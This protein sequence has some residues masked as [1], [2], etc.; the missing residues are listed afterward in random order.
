MKRSVVLAGLSIELFIASVA[1][2]QVQFMGRVWAPRYPEAAANGPSNTGVLENYWASNRP[3]DSPDVFWLSN[4]R[5][6][7]SLDGPGSEALASRTWEMAPSG[8]YRMTGSAGNYSM[9]FTGPA[10][11][12]RPII[13]TNV[14]TGD[15]DGVDR[16]VM[17]TFDYA[18]FHDGAWDPKRASDYYQ[19]F[20]A[21]GASITTVGFRVVHDGVDGEGPGGQ[22]LLASVHKK[23][24][25]TP[26]T[27]EQVGPAVAVPNVDSGGGKMYNWTAAWL[28]GEVPTTPGETYAVHLRAEK[29]GGTFQMFW[30]PDE[31]RESDCYRVGEQGGTGFQGRD[32]WMAISSDCDGLLIAYNKRIQKEYVHLVGFAHKYT[33]TYVARGRS[34]AGVVTYAAFGGAQPGIPR[35]RVAVRVREGG[36]DGPQVGI[37]KIAI[38]NGIHTGDASWGTFGVVFAP[39]EVPL[40]PGKTYAIEME[41]IENYE[42]LHGYVNIKGAVSD[43]RPGFNPY[44]MQAPETYEQG[45]AYRN[46]TED[47]GLDLEMQIVEYERSA[48]NWSQAVDAAN[49]LANGD[50]EKG[51]LADDP[52]NAKAEAWKPFATDPGTTHQY[53]AEGPKK[54]N[55][56]LRVIGGGASGK[57]VD[58]GFVQRVEGLRHL[59]SYRI[60]GK[61]RC[62]WP[63]DIEHTCTVGFDPTGQTDDPKA[64]T[65]V[66]TTLPP[67]HS[68]WV[69]YASTH[70][71]RPKTDAISIWLR[72]W[73]KASTGYPFRADFD[74][75]AVRRVN[76]GVPRLAAHDK[77]VRG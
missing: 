73:T 7:A 25:G 71:V 1:S 63:V 68:V 31:N 60:T 18:V 15:R 26:D 53:L 41:S 34:L 77:E 51:E 38:G 70:P 45:T 74:D 5:C 46:G 43:D 21:R 54:D 10:V 24:P 50:M 17:P 56:I 22:T 4:V 66:W 39:G 62:S 3:P 29:P 49:L 32:L 28:S 13:F 64:D 55:R 59:E 36:P 40:V 8:W 27:W 20:V 9:L 12:I 35:Q 14:Y 44:S 33:Q 61:V 76:T 2:A 52:D 57:T 23:G 47:L 42:S 69:D 37:E 67:L 72:G 6:F 75:F 48:D 30:R 11:F 19:T 58:G 16:K 65:I